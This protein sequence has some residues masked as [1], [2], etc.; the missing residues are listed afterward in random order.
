MISLRF[1]NHQKLSVSDGV[2]N[3]K[4]SQYPSRKFCT[5]IIPINRIIDNS[6]RRIS[7]FREDYVQ[8]RDIN[9]GLPRFCFAALIL[10]VNLLRI[11]DGKYADR[12]TDA[13]A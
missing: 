6:Y 8:S 13:L 11:I 10:R 1:Q 4:F 2:E 9:S 5:N 7:N 3:W 12:N